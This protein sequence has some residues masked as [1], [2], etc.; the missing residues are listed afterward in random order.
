MKIRTGFVSNSSSSSFIVTFPIVPKTIQECHDMM[1]PNGEDHWE[2]TRY[3][4]MMVAEE[5]F[6]DIQNQTGR[7][8]YESMSQEEFIK[9]LAEE[10]AEGG[11]GD[12][13]DRGF[14]REEFINNSP[15]ELARLFVSP[16]RKNPTYRFIFG[17]GGNPLES[18][19]ES[20][21]VFRNLP[22]ENQGGR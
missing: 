18:F 20:N 14:T 22:H 21:N 4:T 8:K 11:I 16:D 5:V 10:I 9:E 12:A 19:M 15:M 13:E 1:W 2:G 6:K 7:G 17:D 3:T